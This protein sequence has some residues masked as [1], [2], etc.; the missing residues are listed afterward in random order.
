MQGD[1][2]PRGN[3]LA[4]V[5]DEENAIIEGLRESL[6]FRNKIFRSVDSAASEEALGEG[7]VEGK[8]EK[9]EGFLCKLGR[10]RTL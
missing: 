1:I 2:M 7:W 6:L 4:G 9:M 8:R 10:K 5:I 3:L